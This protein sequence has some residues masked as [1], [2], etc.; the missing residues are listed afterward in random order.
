MIL[1]ES[2]VSFSGQI[3]LHRSFFPN[4]VGWLKPGNHETMKQVIETMGFF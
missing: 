2:K 3:R 1:E 4:A